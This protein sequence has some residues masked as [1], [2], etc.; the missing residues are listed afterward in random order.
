MIFVTKINHRRELIAAVISSHTTTQFL[1][2]KRIIFA[3]FH[4]PPNDN[5]ERPSGKTRTKSA[6]SRPPQRLSHLPARRSAHAPQASPS[7]GETA[8][9]AA[10]A[11]SPPGGARGRS[12]RGQAGGAEQSGPLR[13]GCLQLQVSRNNAFVEAAVTVLKSK[14]Q[15]GRFRLGRVMH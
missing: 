1:V 2:P 7:N 12:A 8:A 4:L 13:L 9:R 6:P 3:H 14:R 11:R 10:A 15:K 5:L